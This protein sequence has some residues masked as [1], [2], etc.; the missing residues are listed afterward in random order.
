[1]KTVKTVKKRKGKTI[2][3]TAPQSVT[4]KICKFIREL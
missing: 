2:F 3:L 1:M 4:E